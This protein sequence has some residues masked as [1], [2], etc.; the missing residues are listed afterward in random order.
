MHPFT[1]RAVA[2]TLRPNTIRAALRTPLCSPLAA[3]PV[4]CLSWDAQ[5]SPPRLPPDQQA[6][7]EKL[8][9]EAQESAAAASLAD[10]IKDAVA[11]SDARAKAVAAAELED[12][13]N[14]A[15]LH[16]E[17]AERAESAAAATVTANQSV[18]VSTSATAG[19]NGNPIEGVWRGA[20]PEFEGERNPRTGEVGGPKNEPL[21][22]GA[23]GD[24]SY[25]G[26]V[27]DF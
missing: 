20:P 16:A 25:N 22:W 15:A 23:A 24:W 21:R 10:A 18:N 2:R 7:F 14:E 1:L 27:T 13:R 3:T 4:R 8:V 5:P 6:E 12:E 26:R 9:K 17:K 11:L 19:L